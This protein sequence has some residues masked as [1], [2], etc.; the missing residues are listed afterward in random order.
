MLSRLQLSN[1]R[2]YGTAEV[3][4]SSSL[5]V[6]LGDNGSGKTSLLE[7]IY[8]IGSGGRSFRGGRLSRLVRDGAEAATL[9]AEVVGVQDVHR[10]GIRR[11]PGGIDAIKLDGQTPKALSEVAVLLPVLAL[12][13][14]SVELVFGA[15]QLRRRFMDWG[16]FHVE[17]QFMP[18][19]RAGSAALKQRN[20]LLRAG[21][22]NLRELGFW[23][24]QLSQ[25]SDRIE[26]LRRG[27][28]NALQ[29]GLDEAL[30]V[31]APELK[32]RLRLQ[33]GL[34]K[35]ES[36]AQALS[37]LQSDDLRRGFS[38][39]GFHRSD[40]RIESHGVVARDRLSRGQ[41][42]LVA[43]GLVLAQ[44]PMISQSGKVCTLLVDDLA[45]ELDEEHRNQL[46]GYLAT[47]GHQTLITALDMPQWAAIVNDNDALQSVESKMFHVEHGK[48]RS[49][50]ESK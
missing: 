10:I 16:M 34:H 20:A 6:I 44:L 41:A 26:G 23:N 18:V 5:N 13:P 43:Y 15:S 46:L 8:F 14:T 49:L 33:T 1:F 39:A 31:L 4:L 40:I 47:T 7:A 35:G 38:Q 37:R 27:Y 12:H 48:L 9:Y 19:W 45:A 42:K 30:T 22:P 28:L 25:T 50:T 29:R 3:D 11:T 2:N 36:Y 17:H 24:Q 32:I 21:N